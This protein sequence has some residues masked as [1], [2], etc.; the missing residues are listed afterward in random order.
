MLVATPVLTERETMTETEFLM[1]DP[2]LVETIRKEKEGTLKSY[3]VTNEDL[4]E[5]GRLS[6]KGDTKGLDELYEK[7]ISR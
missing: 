7:I 3:R 1:R 5:M 2:V 6:K 4:K